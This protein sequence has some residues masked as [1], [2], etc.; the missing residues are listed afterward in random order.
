MPA[1]NPFS[2]L[3]HK[4]LDLDDGRRLTM[5]SLPAFAEHKGIDLSRLPYVIRL[6]LESTLRHC[7]ETKVLSAHVDALARW[8]PNGDRN[9]EIPFTAGRVLLQD[10]TGIPLLTDLAAMR[11]E[12]QARGHDPRRIEPLVP[13]HLV[14]DHSVQTD[15]T[16]GPDP[17]RRNMEIEFA[18]NG[19]RYA[20]MKWG[21]QAFKTFK[22]IPPGI[23]ICHQIN[24]EHLAEGVI[25]KADVAYPDSLV[26]TDSHTTMINGI[27]VLGWGVGGIEAEAAMLGQP[28]FMLI[29]DVV[30]VRLSGALRPGVTATDAVLTVT[31]HL[32][33]AKVVGQLVEFFGAGVAALGATDRATIANMAPEYGATC[34]YF[35]VDD[36]TLAYYAETGRDAAQVDLISRYFKAQGLFGTPSDAIAYSRVIDIDLASVTSS[37]SGPKRPQDRLDLA[38]LGRRFDRALRSDAAHGGYGKPDAD[39]TR[40]PAGTGANIV[41]GDVLVAAITSCTNTANPKLLITAGLVARK[42][43]ALGLRAKPWVRTL[44]TPGSRAVTAYLGEAGLMAPL[45][46]LGF[47]VSAYGCGACVGNIGPLPADIEQSIL[48][49]DLVCCAVLSGNRNFEARIHAGLRANF[50][51][52]PP[53]VVA[54][55]IAGT[56]RID[57]TRDPLGT[58]ADGSVVTLAD[59]WPTEADI[60]ALSRYARDPRPYQAIYGDLTAG[61]DLWNGIQAAQGQVYDWPPSTYIGRPDFFR[62]AA[63]R[64][65]QGARALAIF[66]DSITTDHISPAGAISAASPAGQWL[67]DRG[68][69]Q[70]DFNTYGAR[71][72]HFEVMVRGTFANARLRNLMLPRRN[73]GAADEGGFTLHYPDGTR[74]SLFEAAMCYQK[75]GVATLIFAGD[76]YGM[77]SSRDWAAKGTRLLGVKAVIA[78]SFE[79]I[80]RSNL[81]GLGV[82]PLQFAAGESVETLGLDGSEVFD[83]VGLDGDPAPGQTV[84]LRANRPDGAAVEAQLTVRIDTAVEAAQFAR[85][86]VLPSV[87]SDLLADNA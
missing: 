39:M 44:F 24:M 43:V 18:R 81:V 33:A 5:V 6:L 4:P 49:N 8:T 73:D 74:T 67:L 72:G 55:A 86:G 65:L 20:L 3:V 47:G 77:G 75:D 79:R 11:S 56:A 76:D 62:T 30:G 32:R 41:H 14:V 46:T 54:L 28:L 17:V 84:T 83:I 15:V 53:L 35:A 10:F 50:L 38:E 48:D 57:L 19:E 52:S 9:Q 31:Q 60:D 59:L 68:V 58:A 70:A 51:A 87:L 80:H 40:S 1:D 23:G 66:G 22:V 26:G 27:G 61:H 13:V 82:L 71:R 12:A 21:M 63:I 69:A 29:P 2:Q 37:L 45:E 42:A 85:G 78:K 25:V 7:D 64:S 34:G 16:E 36:H